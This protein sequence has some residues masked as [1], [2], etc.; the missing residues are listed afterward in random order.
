MIVTIL[1]EDQRG[2]TTKGYGPTALLVACLADTLGLERKEID[3]KLSGVPKKGAGNVNKTI[4]ND[5]A[6]I[7][8]AGPLLA[9]IDRDKVFDHL[10]QPK[11]A[12]NCMQP[13]RQAILDQAQGLVCEI[14]FLID[15]MESLLSTCCLALG[16][17]ALGS[18]P[19]P[20]ERDSILSQVAWS[21]PKVRNQVKNGCPSFARLVDRVAR[22]LYPRRPQ[23]PRLR[24]A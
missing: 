16:K 11:P 3:N 19:T 20:D 23:R 24:P 2:V 15:N 22:P 8:D 21:T 7:L 5:G 4:C 18:K 9:V 12:T 13:V 10:R 1:W 17:E 6:R 14:V